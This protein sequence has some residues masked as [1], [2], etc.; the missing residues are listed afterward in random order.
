MTTSSPT[1]ARLLESFFRQRL[2]AQRRA[3][4]STIAAYRDA[5]RLLLVFVA[6]RKGKAPS[7]LRLEELDRDTVLAFLDH[8]EN[9]RHNSV[10]TRN[11]RLAAIHSFFQH[12]AY[13]DPALMGLAQRILTIPGKR[14]SRRVV[15]YLRHDELESLLEAPDRRTMLGKRDHAVLLFLARTGARVS[16]A[17]AVNVADLRLERPTQV[18]LHG[19]GSKDRVVPLSEDLAVVMQALIEERAIRKDPNAPVFVNARGHRLTRFG[20]RYI[21]SRA[22]KAASQ[23]TPG[24][25][26]RSVTPH[27]LRHT[28]A[29][30]LLQSGVDLTTIQSWLG[31]VA[32][33]TTHHYLE[34]DLEMK[35]KALAQC[36]HPAAEPTRYKPKDEVLALLESM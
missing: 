32:V 7:R 31:H 10:R 13:Y 19:K 27:V 6:D 2:A 29:M 15:S 5:L 3:S 35:R 9:E 28:T 12:V 16:E 33:D 25:V 11:A 30:H 8:L 1:L 22:A 4:S 21:L 20:V 36:D 18:I 23:S 34:A 24:R 17:I 14:S 26:G